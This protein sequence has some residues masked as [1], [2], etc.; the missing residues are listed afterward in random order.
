MCELI[1]NPEIQI[2]SVCDPNKMSTNYIDWSPNGIRDG[3][4]KVLNEPLWGD[5]LTGIPGGRDV[6]KELVDTY[7]SKSKDVKNFKSCTSYADFRELL[8]KEKNIDAVKIMTPDHLHAYISIA[9]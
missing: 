2:V 4:R 5:K 3:I 1:P 6:G 8:D 7:Y 9:A